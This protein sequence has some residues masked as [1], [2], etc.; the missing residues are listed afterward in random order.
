[1]VNEQ[2]STRIYKTRRY[3]IKSVVV[4]H[5]NTYKLPFGFSLLEE[6]IMEVFETRHTLLHSDKVIGPER[7]ALL[8]S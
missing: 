3:K 4:W 7:I 2:V 8:L 1:M 5:G 6:A